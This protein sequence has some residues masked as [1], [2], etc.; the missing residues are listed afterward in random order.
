[1]RAPYCSHKHYIDLALTFS[2]QD[3]FEDYKKRLA[4]KLAKRA[5]QNSSGAQTATEVKKDDMNWFGVK[6][7]SESTGLDLRSSNNGEVGRY[8]NLKRPSDSVIKPADDGK[9]KRKVGFGDF[10]GW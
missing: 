3:P 1:M 7:G 9:K 5:E 10:E 2:Y 6:I 8:L 4:K